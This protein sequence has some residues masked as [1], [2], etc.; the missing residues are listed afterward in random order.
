M[1]KSFDSNSLNGSNKRE[2]DFHSLFKEVPETEALIE[3]DFR[4]IIAVHKRNTAFVIPNAIFISTLHT[5]YFLGS[6]LN[7]DMAYEQIVFRWKNVIHPTETEVIT[8]PNENGD[9]L[10]SDDE[11]V[12]ISPLRK[13]EDTIA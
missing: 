9:T 10:F 13:V 5:K 2:Q 7:R 4:E 8:P 1:S 12:T 11:D 6:F 3:V